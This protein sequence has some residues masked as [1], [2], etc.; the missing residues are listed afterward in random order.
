LNVIAVFCSIV[1]KKVV[2]PN[3]FASTD[4]LS[5]TL[6]T[7]TSRYNQTAR[8]F[9]WKYT[10]SDLQRH[11]AAIPAAALQHH[12]A[13]T[14]WRPPDQPPGGPSSPIGLLPWGR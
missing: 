14:P 1:Q 5:G 7:F 4:D 3:D 9:S 11:L 6:L 8:P 2:T 12:P 10:A 13:S